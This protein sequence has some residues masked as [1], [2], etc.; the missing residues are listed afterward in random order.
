[1]QDMRRYSLPLTQERI[2]ICHP[3]CKCRHRSNVHF[4][5]RTLTLGALLNARRA[6]DVE[7][8]HGK[9]VMQRETV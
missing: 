4:G 3:F 1:M 6:R 2:L 8:T 9:K 5:T 7:P